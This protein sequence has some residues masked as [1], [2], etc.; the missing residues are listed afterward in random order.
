MY[1]CICKAITDTQ[2]RRAANAGID[3]VYELRE[4]LGVASGCGSCASAAQAILDESNLGAAGE[5]GIYS[6]FSA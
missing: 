2:I 3:N 5:P 1:I 6:P 4:R